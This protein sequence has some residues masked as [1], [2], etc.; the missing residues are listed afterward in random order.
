MGV[1][2]VYGQ[3]EGVRYEHPTL[4][5][6]S[7]RILRMLSTIFKGV[8]GCLKSIYVFLRYLLHSL[9]VYTRDVLQG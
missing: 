9:G 6:L 3:D 5:V 2:L 1:V 4:V 7:H 8:A